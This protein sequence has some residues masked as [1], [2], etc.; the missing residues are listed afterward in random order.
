MSDLSLRLVV[1]GGAV[2]LV[3][4]IVLY[5]RRRD[6]AESIRV[7]RVDLDPGIYL[8][9]SATCDTCEKARRR[10]ERRLGQ[11][12]FVEYTWESHPETFAAL[13]IDRVPSSLVV[14]A[15]GRGV[16]WRGQ[17]DRMISTVDP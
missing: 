15:G 8:F 12:G 2:V 17:P 4:L 5:L 9:T 14:E 11:A 6:L 10:L 3:L 7:G 16:L 1:V 13:G